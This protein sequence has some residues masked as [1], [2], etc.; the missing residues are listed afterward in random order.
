MLED[1]LLNIFKAKYNKYR[2][3][4]HNL[5][6]FD[7][8]YIIRILAKLAKSNNYNFKTQL[9]DGKIINLTLNYGPGNNKLYNL[10]F[11]DSYL[12]MPESLDI[13]AKAM[14]VEHKSLFPIYYPGNVDLN[15]IGRCLLRHRL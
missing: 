7:S 9:K 1:A 12:L 6:Y 14:K 15:Y 11:R 13:L 5:S 8:I 4:F 2:V 10:Y 3:Y